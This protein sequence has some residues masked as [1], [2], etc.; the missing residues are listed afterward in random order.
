MFFIIPSLSRTTII[1]QKTLPLLIEKFGIQ[2]TTIYVFVI[3]EEYLEY[4]HQITT[5]YPN[6]QIQTGPLGLHHM[7]N[8]IRKFF[9]EGTKMVCLDDDIDDIVEMREDLS[10]ENK[11]SCKRYPLHSLTSQEFQI[12]LSNAFQILEERKIHLFGFYPVK[13]GY[14][15][16]S[17]PNISYDLRFCVGSFWGCI[18]Q[19]SSNLLLS[20]EE[21]EDFER[22]LQYYTQDSSV[23]RYNHISPVTNYYKEK[24]GMQSRGMDRKKTSVKSTQYLLDNY[25]NLCRLY[26]AKKNGIYEV[27][28]I[29]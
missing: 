3:E 1:L 13:N 27:K 12:L 22:T 28:L 2:Q 16:K 9:P 7:R 17:L 18:N 8:H 19:H 11:K 10:I 6:V 26:T 25:P 20:I 21:K 4:F 5:K 29:P 15:M 23:L 14:F 24:G